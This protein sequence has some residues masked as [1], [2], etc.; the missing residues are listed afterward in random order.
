MLLLVLLLYG[1]DYVVCGDDDG[2]SDDGASDDGSASDDELG[3]MIPL[4]Y[5]VAPPNDS[6][7]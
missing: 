6:F 7:Q 2:A 3:T 4:S 5:K 1:G